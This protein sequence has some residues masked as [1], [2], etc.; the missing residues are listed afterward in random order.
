MI[1]C[2]IIGCGNNVEDLHIPALMGIN[3]L[4]I[5]AACD[6]NAN[7]LNR[8]GEKYG[9]KYLFDNFEMFLRSD[10][11]V[12][13]IDISTPGF[14][15][16]ELCREALDAGYNLLVEKPVTLSLDQTIEL[17]NIVD[18]NDSKFCVIQNYRFRDCSLKARKDV[19]NGRVGKIHQINV[20]FHGQSVFS[21][22][23]PWVWNERK[24]KSLLYEICLHYLD[25]Q[26]FFA[27]RV[28]KI[29]G[30]ESSWDDKTETT[31][32]LYAM[33]EHENGTIGI[34]DLQ[35]NASSNYTHLEIFGSAND[36][37]IKFFPEYYR[38]YSG[39]IN[40]IDEVYNDVKRI[41]DFGIPTI[42]EKFL[43]PKINRRAKSHYRLFK[44]FVKALKENH[45]FVP[46]SL[47]DV[48][49]TMELA[50]HLSKI[51]Y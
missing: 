49:P 40:P 11:K 33:V 9:I 10:I 39:N 15:H 51:A 5:A 26:V 29:I 38:I 32:K 6:V 1:R 50:E 27:G 8:F 7:R 14:T 42:K 43:K 35:F 25:L 2:A 19:E 24:N 48:I 37:L 23:A 46:V 22:P 4:E 41:I 31:E 30:A 44:L 17:K 45:S 13:F 34:I 18:K 47:D 16:F 21:E 28:K 3:D 20:T 36:I 12:D